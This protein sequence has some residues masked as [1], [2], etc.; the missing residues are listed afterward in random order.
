[1][2]T[3]DASVNK[4]LFKHRVLI[5]AFV[6][7]FDA[8]SRFNE[9]RVSFEQFALFGFRI[10]TCLMELTSLSFSRQILFS[11]TAMNNVNLTGFWPC[12]FPTHA[13]IVNSKV[14]VSFSTGKSFRNACYYAFARAM[15]ARG[16]IAHPEHVL[17]A[18][19]AAWSYESVEG[20]GYKGLLDVVPM[21]HANAAED[22]DNPAQEFAEN[23][24]AVLLAGGS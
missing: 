4:G 9:T 16:Q 14:R 10:L 15:N 8:G 12:L 21:S 1:M 24:I 5:E 23:L 17:R 13:E 19:R 6:A 3:R 2:N 11:Q 7:A 20:N 18:V 22:A